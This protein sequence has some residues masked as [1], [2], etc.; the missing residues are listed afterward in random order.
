VE[1]D[2]PLPDVG[3]W[4]R[5]AVSVPAVTLALVVMLA[6]LPLTLPLAALTDV[7]RRS[8]LA[9][10][11]T[12]LFM[13]LFLACEVIG[14]AAC[15]LI[16]LRHR[17]D[18]EVFVEAN[19]QL[20]RWWS[21]T[22]SQGLEVLY[23]MRYAVE[24]DAPGDGPS[25]LLVRHVSSADTLLPMRL[26]AVPNDLRVRYVLKRELAADPCLD[27]VGHRLPN[28]FVDRSGRSREGAVAA[29]RRLVRGLGDRDCGVIFPEGTRF[30]SARHERVLKQ[31]SGSPLAD[32][33]SQL[34]HSLPPRTGGVLAMLDGAPT[35]DVY[36]VGHTGFEGVRTMG[37]LLSG[38]LVDRVVRIRFRRVASS[39]IPSGEEARKLWLY[40]EWLDQDRWIGRAYS[41]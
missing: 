18:A 20:Q 21:G 11:R 19:H 14:V 2:L 13:T 1:A 28:V 24:G 29:V 27:I 38:A 26:V 41:G 37:D 10:A 31:L 23:G 34:T 12:V 33:G 16:W 5:R 35:A 8:R 22:L 25:L 9:V 15:V 39:E 32:L 6:A 40:R 17:H 3:R 36:F 4:R 30:T 7:L